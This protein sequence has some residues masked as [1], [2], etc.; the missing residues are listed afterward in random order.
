V[1]AA[2]LALLRLELLERGVHLR[3]REPGSR[4]AVRPGREVVGVMD[5]FGGVALGR[6]ADQT[7]LAHELAD[8]RRACRVAHEVQEHHRRLGLVGMRL[9]ERLD[10][11]PAERRRPIHP[12]VLDALQPRQHLRGRDQR[13]ARLDP[14]PRR[15]RVGLERRQRERE[16]AVRGGQRLQVIADRGVDGIELLEHLERGPD[17]RRLA[18]RPAPVGLEGVAVAAVGGAVGSERVEHGRGVAAEVAVLEAALLEHAGAGPDRVRR[19]GDRLVH[20]GHRTVPER[21]A[22]E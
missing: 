10:L 19:A 14:P 16:P 6:V 12:R 5:L 3:V 4:E 13:A 9:L 15:A 18:D 17:V 1:P 7:L 11:L 2:V 20:R 21:R 8:P 22:I